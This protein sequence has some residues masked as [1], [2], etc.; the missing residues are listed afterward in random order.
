[1][2]YEC[3]WIRVAKERVQLLAFVL[4]LLVLLRGN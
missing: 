1:M 2:E 3:Q 4:K